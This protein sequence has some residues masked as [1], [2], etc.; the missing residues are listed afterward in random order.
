[1]NKET[2]ILILF[3]LTMLGVSSH[4]RDQ[5]I[6]SIELV[7]ARG[8]G[9]ASYT[10]ADGRRIQCNDTLLFFT[11]ELNDMQHREL[12]AGNTLGELTSIRADATTASA[13]RHPST[14]TRRGKVPSGLWISLETCGS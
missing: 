4:G 3:T 11:F 2:R 14:H 13:R 12:I 9:V 1:M 6:K 8:V 7:T 5:F 10:A